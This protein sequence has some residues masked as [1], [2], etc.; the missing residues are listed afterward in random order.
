MKTCIS[1]GMPMKTPSEFAGG[2]TEKDYCVHC[3]HS[4]GSM[5]SFEE[6]K[7]SLTQFII[8]TQGLDRAVAENAAIAMMKKLPAWAEYLT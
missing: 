3:A 7:A 8:K 2:D 6:Q 1:C 5:K 4:D